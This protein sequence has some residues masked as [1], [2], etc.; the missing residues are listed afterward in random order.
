RQFTREERIRLVGCLNAMLQ[1]EGQVVSVGSYVLRK[2][3]QVQLRDDLD[4]RVRQGTLALSVTVTELQV[5]FSVLA[6]EGSAD[7]TAAGQAYDAGMQAL[8]P[9]AR[10]P[11]GVP[12]NWPRALDA[13][14]N[15][16]DLLSPQAKEQLVQALLKTIASDGKL[17]IEEAELLRAVCASIH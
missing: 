13:A 14:L 1:R 10:P 6:Q 16:L 8:Y 7:A 2:L 9:R 11:F 3:T 5:L 15:R 12:A 17:A 4:P